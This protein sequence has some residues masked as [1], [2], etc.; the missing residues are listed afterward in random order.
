[1]F[2][3]RGTIVPNS[4]IHSDS[5]TC[6]NSIN[7]CVIL[8]TLCSMTTCIVC[9]DFFNDQIWNVSTLMKTNLKCLKMFILYLQGVF[10]FV[11]H[12]LYRCYR[13][14]TCI[15]TWDSYFIYFSFLNCQPIFQYCV[16]HCDLGKF[17]HF[18]V[19]FSKG[20]RPLVKSNHPAKSTRFSF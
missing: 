6:F 16:E 4:L 13:H 14:V 7:V 5:R 9:F 10:A 1:M 12:F 17:P 11:E 20:G 19:F 2:I 18:P 3:P 15:V 8:W